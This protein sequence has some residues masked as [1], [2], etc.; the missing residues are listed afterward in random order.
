MTARHVLVTGA[1]RG[2]GEG[3]ARAFAANGA[4]VSLLVRDAARGEAVA[5]GMPGRHGVVV[6]DVTDA[7]AVG[8][9]VAAAVA[10]RG[11]VDVLV[12]NAGSA[13]SAPFLKTSP[14]RFAKLFAEHLLGAVHTAQAVLPGMVQRRAGCI[15]NVAST[16]GLDGAAYVSAYVSAKHALVGLTRALA[17]EFGETGVTVHAVCPGYVDTELVRAAVERVAAKTARSV[18]ESLISFLA[19]AKQSRLLS[20]HEVAAAVVELASDARRAPNGQVVRL[21]GS[22]RR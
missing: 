5:A 14:E 12:N 3:I 10:A 2:I 20:V 17:V 13:D 4:S 6:A 7:A 21:D 8:R 9:A 18:A 16:A 19:S 11:P 1:N 15:V 22:E